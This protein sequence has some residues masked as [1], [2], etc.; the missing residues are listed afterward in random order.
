MSEEPRDDGRNIP[1]QRANEEDRAKAGA[2]T[3]AT[4]AGCLFT[5]LMPW[6]LLIVVFGIIAIAW[7]VWQLATGA[8]DS[9]SP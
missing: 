1:A 6:S 3:A 5:A 2:A 7:F 9:P 4:G 8:G